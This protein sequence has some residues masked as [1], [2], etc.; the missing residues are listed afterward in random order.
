MQSILTIDKETTI[1]EDMGKNSY[2][3]S[4]VHTAVKKPGK[5]WV[6]SFHRTYGSSLQASL[7]RDATIAQVSAF[8]HG[9]T[10][11]GMGNDEET[12][13]ALGYRRE[14]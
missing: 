11:E 4:C 10:P 6:L 12:H 7:R 2:G 3:Q 8:L 13:L 5:R 14:E 9:E 1:T